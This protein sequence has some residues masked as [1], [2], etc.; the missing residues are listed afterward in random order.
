MGTVSVQLKRWA[1][2]EY[3]RLV[4][5]GALGPDDRV[6]LIE[7]E[8]V[9]M[10]PQGPGHAT[11]VTLLLDALR[12]AFPAGYVVRAQ[13]PL[14]VGVFSEPEPDVAVVPGDPREYRDQHPTTAVLV[15]EVAGTTLE[16]DRTRKAQLYA[17]AGIP[18]YWVLNLVD[19]TLEILRD[20]APIGEG[21]GEYRATLRL[22]VAEQ[23]APLARPDHTIAVADLLP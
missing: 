22:G 3:D 18:E 17:D 4:A 8:I 23:V 21:R 13:L 11:A 7:G 14:A 12:T 16:F 15:A 9:E 19:R 2:K 6:Q 10:A 20:P 5:L 1:R